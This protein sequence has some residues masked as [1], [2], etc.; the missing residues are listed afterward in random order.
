MAGYDFRTK[1]EAEDTLSFFIFDNL[2][3][4][5]SGEGGNVYRFDTMQEAMTAFRMISAEH[6]GWTIALGGSVAGEREIDFVQRREG[7]MNVLVDDYKRIP[8]WANRDDV[9]QAIKE[10]A[11]GPGIE[12][13]TDRELLG[14]PVLIP[15][16]PESASEDPVLADKALL[17]TDSEDALTSVSE[18]YV[19]GQ[20]WVDL[21]QLKQMIRDH[22]SNPDERPRVSRLNVAYET[23]GKS[24]GERGRTGYVDIKPHEMY[25]MADRFHELADIRDQEREERL[26]AESHIDPPVSEEDLPEFDMGRPFFDYETNYGETERVCITIGAYAHDENIYL[27]MDFFDRDLGAMDFYGDITVNITKLQPFMACIDTNNNG[28]KIVDF[29]VKNGLAEPAGRSL[30]SGF[31]MYPVFRINPEK[32]REVDPRGFRQYCR[33]AGI[34]TKQQEASKESLAALKKE[35][36]ERAAG[37]NLE[38]PEKQQNRTRSHDMEL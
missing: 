37:R 13:Q 16:A 26:E 10:F 1:P 14:G 9:A 18:A 15:Y 8:F 28:E 19:Q 25:G 22:G 6:P 2:K 33:A 29:L 34:E 21:D 11:E 31:C 4:Q 12:W 7:W 36:R 23:M 27:G 5:E 30:P 20:G 24:G 17:P 32:L 35:A 3:M 38:R